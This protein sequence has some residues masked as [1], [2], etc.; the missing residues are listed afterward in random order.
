MN[1]SYVL[2]LVFPIVFYLLGTYVFKKNNTLKTI[3]KATIIYIVI[4]A[5]DLTLK[6]DY[7]DSLYKIGISIIGVSI[8]YLF[9][10]Y[11]IKKQNI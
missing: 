9:H 4:N 11:R 5:I 3:L 10:R 8:T 1:I 6:T 7:R 2:I